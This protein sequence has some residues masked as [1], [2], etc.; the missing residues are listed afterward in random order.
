MKKRIIYFTLI[1]ALVSIFAMLF[2]ANASA[3]EK[4]ISVTYNWYNGSVWETASP[5]A[6]GSYTL[7]TDKKS[8]NG[9]V[10]LNDGTV[11]DKEFYGWFDEVGN[12]YGA[13]ET[14]T[15]TKS[16]RLYEAYGVTVY[17]A[18]DF[19]K[20]LNK[21]QD[22]T[23]VKLGADITM[24]KTISSEWDTMVINLNGHNLTITVDDNAI[25]VAR[26]AFI[27]HGEGTVTHTPKTTNKDDRGFVY[28]S[29]HSYGDEG[30]P[31]LFWIGKDVKITSPYHLLYD[32]GIKAGYN[33]PDMVI[34][35]EVNTK[36]VA[37]INPDIETA[38]CY[39]AETAKLNLTTDFIQFKSQ[40]NSVTY[41]YITLDGE[42]NLA[43]GQ[44]STL[45]ND[46]I[47]ARTAIKLNGGKFCLPASD[48]EYL[49]Y[50]LDDAHMFKDVTEGELTYKQV[51]EADCVH[52]WV[53][54]EEQSVE[55][56]LGTNGKDVFNCSLC[57]TNKTV[58]TV[59]DIS[60]AEIDI[61]VV[62][63]NGER[64]TVTV[65]SGDVFLYEVTGVGENSSFTF[66][67]VKGSPIYPAE[68]IVSIQIP[69]GVSAILANAANSTLEEIVI[70]DDANVSV[71]GMSGLTGLKTINIGA[72][73][74]AFKT[75]VKTVA[76]TIKS[77]KAG[78]NITF[79]SKSFHNATTLKNLILSSGSTYSFGSES[80]RLAGLSELVF[81][82]NSTIS[83]GN[84][85]FAECQSL[86]YIYFGSNIGVKK[87]ND[88][89]AVFDGIS[90]LKTVV[91]M[92]LTYLGQWAFSTKDPGK[93]FGPLCDVEF[94]IHSE[95]IETHYQALNTRNGAYHVY[96]YTLNAPIMS[97]GTSYANCN[98]T[99]Y[100]GLPH[101]YVDD[102]ITESTCVTP[103]TKG[104]KTDC[105][106]GVDYRTVTYTSTSTFDTALNG[107]THEPFGTDI[108]Y[109]PLSNE[110]TESDI[111]KDIIYF[112]GYGKLGTEAYKCLYCDE[113][114][115]Y[116]EEPSFDAL[117]ISTGYSIN[118]F[119]NDGFVV[120][121]KTNIE[122]IA[123]YEEITGRTV[124]YGLYISPS[125]ALGKNEVLDEN[126]S[127][128]AGAVKMRL[129]RDFINMQMK[130]TNII[131][132]D[133]K[134]ILL[135]I[136]AYVEI[137]DGEAKKYG[138][139]EE[140][141]PN[142]GEKH[143]FVSYNSILASIG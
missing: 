88:N 27:M 94:Y 73:T 125:I 118:E 7:R 140:G 90:N 108:S 21:S 11:V 41:M 133:Q 77:E 32:T 71:E 45:L 127:P 128:I 33:M 95:S 4:A 137:V 91:I 47:L 103:G 102:V 69:K 115:K 53:K 138:Y 49:K 82:D 29:A 67:G 86:E 85:A 141:T 134:N 9:T 123:K 119:T 15:F 131:T 34:A 56:V 126:G 143:C 109:L 101:K 55:A 43:N 1:V 5:N 80:F 40:N 104:Y 132:E 54:D 74:V 10:T 135:A 2:A 57:Q 120:G 89:T 3:E 22:S 113:I 139:I 93:Q 64:K 107:V 35:G 52:V 87:V 48:Y 83:W 79:D 75:G 23:Y 81:P 19:Y 17:N 96:M 136:G 117:I 61:V 12:L 16:T 111:L 31:Q 18:D 20:V 121:Y 14:V 13:G 84:T 42:I 76:E 51:V 65:R 72:A 28:F 66:V 39:I 112:S 130:V 63:E 98:I 60:N 92:D 26:G 36:T 44:G 114:S 50:Y 30:N 62:D 68:T 25:K 105:P 106:C 37:R 6:D 8:G 116:E 142:E 38:R 100:I 99:Q 129:E 122:A 70:L 59:Y 24:E 110:H 124:G 58:I 97:K 78:A 46:F